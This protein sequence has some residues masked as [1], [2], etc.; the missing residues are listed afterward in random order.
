MNTHDIGFARD[1]SKKRCGY[2]YTRLRQ[3]CCGIKRQVRACAIHAIS[4]LENKCDEIVRGTNECQANSIKTINRLS[5]GLMWPR[6]PV[7]KKFA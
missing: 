3:I 2:S 5:F 7:H 4:G 1:F 6:Q